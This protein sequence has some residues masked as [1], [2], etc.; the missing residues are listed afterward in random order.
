MN[1]YCDYLDWQIL[2]NYLKTLL[3]HFEDW[4]IV[5]DENISVAHTAALYG[6]LPIDF[7]PN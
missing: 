6:N 4:N 3:I 1:I 5:T 7:P 2:E